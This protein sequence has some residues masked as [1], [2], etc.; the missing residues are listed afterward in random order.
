M[1]D[2]GASAEYRKLVVAPARALR[3]AM[4]RG[5]PPETEVLAGREF[6]GTNTPW[7]APLLGIRRFVKGF[8]LT[9]DGGLSGYNVRVVGDD[10]GSAWTTTTWRGQRE[11]GFFSVAPVDPEAVDN[12]HLNAV[13]L[14]Y[15]AF[16]SGPDPT[17]ALR[18]YLVRVR[19]DSELLLG[20]AFL[21]AGPLRLP[22]GYFVLEPLPR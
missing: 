7:V 6:R 18:D 15:G 20:Q 19:P 4:Q 9:D 22:V 12:Q 3:A 10:L 17:R 13:L 2:T 1:T 11:F 14:D 5:R 16:G 21:A 8:R